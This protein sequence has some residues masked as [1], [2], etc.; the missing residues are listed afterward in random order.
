MID[1]VDSPLPCAPPVPEPASEDGLT[2]V[3]SD[4]VVAYSPR[5]SQAAGCSE[6]SSSNCIDGCM[7]MGMEMEWSHT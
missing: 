4:L 3:S 5:A 2:S 6:L 7:E 1:A